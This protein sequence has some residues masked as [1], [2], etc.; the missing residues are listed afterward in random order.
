MWMI[1]AALVGTVVYE[2]VREMRTRAARVGIASSSDELTSL[3][4]RAAWEEP[5]AARADPGASRGVAV[6]GGVVRAGTAST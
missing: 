5:A 4:S 3:P 6:L 2:L 1:T